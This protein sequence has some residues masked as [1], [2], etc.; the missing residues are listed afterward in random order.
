LRFAVTALLA[1]APGALAHAQQAPAAPLLLDQS[2]PAPAAPQ[3]G[4]WISGDEIAQ[5]PTA[6]AAW[7]RLRAD[8]ARDAGV[9]NVADQNSS[10]D[11]YTLA[12]ALVC[13][14]SGEYC[15]KARRSVM[16]AI[17]SEEGGR[18]LAVGRNLMAY[19]IA[20]DLLDLRRG[21]APDGDRVE[22]WIA[23]FL[24][25]TLRHNN[26]DRQVPLEPFASGSNAS[27]QEGAVYVALAAYLADGSALEYAWN[28]YRRFVCDPA[29][30]DPGAIDLSKGVAYG[31]SHDDSRP[32]A[33]NPEGSM[34]EVPSGLPGAGKLRRLDGA[35]IND[36]RRGGPFQWVP[37]Y[38]QYPWVGLEGL[39]PAAL[40]LQ[41]AGYPAFESA[42]RAVLRSLEYLWFMRTETGNAAWFDGNR[43]DEVVHLVNIV[44]G[45]AWPTA[46]AVGAG[47]TV[48][49]TDWSH[50]R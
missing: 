24:T 21:G 47:R 12:Q 5:R 46:A 10:H 28:A 49:Y 45:R 36:M 22:S 7:E 42:D 41:R 39:V 44:Y 9:A 15:D 19:V 16:S 14:R 11:V 35:I 23:Q 13:V 27:A 3:T 50:A 8:A 2:D 17:G 32:C 25:R 48:G 18:W 30:P 6:G 20:A 34:K 40:M 43:A 29:A 1:L 26:Q 31:W 33:I 4:I 38:T 37:G